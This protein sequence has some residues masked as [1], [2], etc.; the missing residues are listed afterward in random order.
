MHD[1]GQQLQRVMDVESAISDVEAV[2]VASGVQET[3]PKQ[4]KLGGTER[5]RGKSEG[6]KCSRQ[7][8]SA[9]TDI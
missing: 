5:L 8:K 9:V 7:T 3:R 6:K 2:G 1:F 4:L